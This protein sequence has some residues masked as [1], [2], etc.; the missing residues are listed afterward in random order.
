M[1]EE[2]KDS[3]LANGEATHNHGGNKTIFLTPHKASTASITSDVTVRVTELSSKG[4][5]YLGEISGLL[6]SAYF[7]SRKQVNPAPY[8]ISVENTVPEA[9]LLIHLAETRN[10]TREWGNGRGDI[11]GVPEYFRNISQHFAKEHNLSYTEIV[12]DDLAKQ[13]FGLM[14][15]VGRASVNKPVFVNLGYKGNPNSESWVAFVGKGVCFDTG[16]L[17]IKTGKT[18]NM[19]SFGNVR[20][21]YGQIGS[22]HCSCRLP[23]NRQAKVANQLDLQ[24]RIG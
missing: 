24:H 9:E 8:V 17:N 19:F 7:F 10:Q 18:L 6:S 21:V 5:E 20:H 22:N 3:F 23:N 2:L 14:H 4:K 16:G 12:G 1:P 15:A 13:G 11:Q